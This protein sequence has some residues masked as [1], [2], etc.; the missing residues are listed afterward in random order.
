[1]GKVIAITGKGGTGKTAV[2]AIIIRSLLKRD[3]NPTILAIDADPD[4]NLADALGD[5]VEMTVG[6]IREEIQDSRISLPPDY[7]KKQL[8]AA[9]IF[10]ALLEK[11]GY[12]L[13]VMGRSEGSGCYCYLNSLLKGIMD[14]TID[15]YD[16][17]LVDSPAGLEHLSRKT[18]SEVDSLI[19]V[20]DESR[21]GLKTAETI[22]QLADELDLKYNN[23][24]VIANKVHELSKDQIQEVASG[25]GLKVIGLI[26]YDETVARLDL[27]GDPLVDLPDDSPAVVEVEE[28]IIKEIGL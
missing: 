8:F 16:L 19:V 27:V 24:Y 10:E 4:A 1:M 23:L 14:E 20:T 18:I 12:D 25:L 9:K 2:T 11:D 21:R 26:P 28:R 17:V 7:D 13:L 3:D 22:R 15:D 5:D 6:D